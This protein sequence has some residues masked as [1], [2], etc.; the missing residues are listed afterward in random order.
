MCKRSELIKSVDTT[1]L[2]ELFFNRVT[3]EIKV[4][5]L[6]GG[7]VKGS[8]TTNLS[9]F[10]HPSEFMDSLMSEVTSCVGFFGSCDVFKVVIIDN[11]DMSF[12]EVIAE[13]NRETL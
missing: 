3:R 11:D 7:V 5:S 9:P 13:L 1:K 2:R 8:K 10:M 12:A 6:C 4:D